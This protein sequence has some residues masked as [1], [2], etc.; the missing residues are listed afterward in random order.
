ML[1]PFT[2]G[3]RSQLGENIAEIQPLAAGPR[4]HLFQ[5]ID[6]IK[7]VGDTPLYDAVNTGFDYMQARAEPGR[8]TAI[9]VL[10]DGENNASSTTIE[11]LESKMRGSSESGDR[12]PVRVFPIVY[13]GD[14]PPEALTR[15]AVA[16]GGQVFDA[17]DPR[18]L[19]ATLASVFSNF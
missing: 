16:S 7:P 13:T 10:S 1:C 17:K 14:A 6:N 3:T 5:E 12:T 9:V 15:I 4:E 18:R 19:R 8:N 2:T 11:A